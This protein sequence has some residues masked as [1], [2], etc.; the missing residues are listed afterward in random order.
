MDSL[1]KRVRIFFSQCRRNELPQGQA[2]NEFTTIRRDYYKV[3]EDA[4]EKV[5]LASQMYSLGRIDLRLTAVN[6]PVE[7]LSH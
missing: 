5:Q 4:D 1:E 3:L 6:R 2:D 7:R